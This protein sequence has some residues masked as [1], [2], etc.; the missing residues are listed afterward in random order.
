MA[1]HLQYD[2]LEFHG[3]QLRVVLRVPRHLVSIVGKTVF[4]KGLGTDSRSEAEVRA[5]PILREWNA[6]IKAAERKAKAAPLDPITATALEDRINRTII[7]GVVAKEELPGDRAFLEQLDAEHYGPKAERIAREHSPAKAREYQGIVRGE[8]TPIL[9]FV[10][11]WLSDRGDLAKRTAKHYRDTITQV[12]AF[13]AKESIP[14]TLEGFERSHAG[15]LISQRFLAP[16]VPYK[17]ARK[18]VSAASSYWNWLSAKGKLP[19]GAPD[20]PWRGQVMPQKPSRRRGNAKSE[21][22]AFTD[23]EVSTLLYRGEPDDVLRDFMMIAALSG[24][25]ID[26]IGRIKV[27][28]VDIK[29]TNALSIEEAKSDAGVRTV[30][31]HP[32]IESI[33]KRRIANKS[34]DDW[35]FPELPEYPPESLSERTMTITK[36]FVTYRRGLGVDERVE[37]KRNSRITFHSFRKW[38]TTKAERASIPKSTVAFVVGHEEG[39]EGMTFGLY[40]DGPSLEQLKACVK[41]VRLPPRPT[42]RQPAVSTPLSL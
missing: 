7:A 14:Q 25:R 9:V 20:N 19:R 42:S 4:K 35:L 41:A 26:E 39:R 33:I 16:N 28:N 18:F 6:I 22:R 17:T 12:V 24:M 10:D 1:A 37:G 15:D 23:D 3:R 21:P 11:Q 5:W 34:P 27:Q 29:F 38:F 32:R 30:P 13:A 8:R 31:I 36:R 2:H 40:S